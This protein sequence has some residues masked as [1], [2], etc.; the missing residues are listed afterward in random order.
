MGRKCSVC[1][2]PDI[3]DI[4]KHLIYGT[5]TYADIG[6][7]YGLSTFALKRHKENHL[8]PIIDEAAEETRLQAK[9]DTIATL[10]AVDRVIREKFDVVLESSNPSYGQL[11]DYLKF[12]S[13]MLGETTGPTQVHVEWGP[14][15]QEDG[16]II[17]EPP[18][19]TDNEVEEIERYA[20]KH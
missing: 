5:T 12:R 4:N 8:S 2:H 19:L 10:D 20:R 3:Q 18:G 16:S 1:A 6:R 14:T 17:K 9:N 15:I 13:G 7:M 11:L